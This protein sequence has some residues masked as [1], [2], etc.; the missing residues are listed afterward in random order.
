MAAKKPRSNKMWGCNPEILRR[1]WSNFTNGSNYC[2]LALVFEHA[3][4]GDVD[5]AV[6]EA[7]YRLFEDDSIAFTVA[8]P[9]ALF[10]IKCLLGRNIL[11]SMINGSEDNVGVPADKFLY[12]VNLTI[13]TSFTPLLFLVLNLFLLCC[14][15]YSGSPPTLS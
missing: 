6:K 5:R 15:F 10:A 8:T 14:V 12:E 4:N 1:A 2:P 11:F 7:K 13:V 3:V 9:V